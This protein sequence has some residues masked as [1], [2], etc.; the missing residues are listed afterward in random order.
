MVRAL[1]EIAAAGLAADGESRIRQELDAF[2][3]RPSYAAAVN[4]PLMFGSDPRV[5]DV[6]RH[7][8][9][10]D[11]TPLR[12]A[13]VLQLTA[14]GDMDAAVQVL[15]G[16]PS[17]EVRA[18]AADALGYYW[19]GEGEAADVL[20]DAQ[21]DPDPAVAAAAT[22]ARRRLKLAKRPRPRPA[23][24]GPTAEIDDRYPWL[25]FLRRWSRDLL[26]VE[27]FALT[28]DD[29]VVEGGWLGFPAAAESE[30]ATL[31]A[32]LGRRLPRSYRSFLATTNGF[33]GGGPAIRRIRPAGEVKPF[34][35]EEREWVEIWAASGP[36]EE[37]V[38]L[39]TAVQVSD[40]GDGAV[41]LLCPDVVHAGGEWEAWLFANWVPG[42]RRYASWWALLQAE[43]QGVRRTG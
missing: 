37:A 25:E 14:L 34:G 32:R 42:A 28:Q 8:L 16:D 43:H 20:L 10:A 18:A 30:I 33:R 39:R 11:A 38:P 2:R 4:L 3:A 21:D 6:L 35:E 31:E 29:A 13:A 22:K 19:T 36:P 15:R 17:A 26:S 7:A 9:K 40:V 12:R 23:A 41:Y 5:L 24:A 27:E 1:A